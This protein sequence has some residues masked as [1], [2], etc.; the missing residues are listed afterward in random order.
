MTALAVRP[1]IAVERE[2]LGTR[3]GTVPMFVTVPASAT[4]EQQAE[5][6]YW[7]NEIAPLFRYAGE[8]T[9]TD[10]PPRGAEIRPSCIRLL[11]SG[12]P[13]D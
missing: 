5:M 3:A 10:R 8:A 2:G 6:D 13:S 9:G 4:P 1:E 7:L 12:G 11:P